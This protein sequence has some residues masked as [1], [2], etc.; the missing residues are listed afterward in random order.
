MPDQRSPCPGCGA[1]FPDS[2]GPTHRYLGASA[3]CWATYGEVLAREYQD[4]TY[5]AAHRLTVDAYAV[6][7]PGRESSQTVRSVA[8]H[9]VGLYAGLERGLGP[10]A[11]R[12][13][14]GRAAE[15]SA[16]RWLSRPASLGDVTV[17]DVVGAESAD[18]HAL[19]VRAWAESAW[20]AWREH[21]EQVRAWFD[22]IR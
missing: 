6:Q 2:D 17:A 4:P 22:A 21:H 11:A 9:L 5:M 3:G 16:Y 8:L 14:I 7:H 10:D 1:R 19:A 15:S 13:V 12:D 18:E 20:G